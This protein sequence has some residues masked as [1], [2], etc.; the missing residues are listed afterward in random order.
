LRS[1][2]QAAEYH[3][4]PRGTIDEALVAMKRARAE[5]MVVQ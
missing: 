5:L 2:A 3:E 4:P 1:I